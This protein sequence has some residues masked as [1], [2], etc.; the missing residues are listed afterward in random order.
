[1]TETVYDPNCV[2]CPRLASYLAECHAQHPQY[3]CRPVPS[4]GDPTPRIVL[5][6]LAPGLHGANRTG[7]P[8]TGDH[9][10]I[11]LYETLFALGL[12]TSAESRSADDPLELRS[13]RIVNSVKCAPPDN[14]PLPDEIRRCNAY[15]K[16]ELARLTPEELREILSRACGS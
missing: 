6:G 3:W 12:S 14:K 9:A 8:F 10:G 11:L 7:R 4:F 15:L 1:M 13:V 16:V 5:V 2:R